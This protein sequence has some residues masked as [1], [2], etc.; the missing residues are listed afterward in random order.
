MRTK[1]WTTKE[2]VH[3]YA[4]RLRAVELY[5]RLGKR[6][7]G[8]SRHLGYPTTNSIG[9]APRVPAAS[10]PGYSAGSS[11]AEMLRESEAGGIGLYSGDES[12][13]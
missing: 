11:S 6:L 13:Q 10:P 5:I 12:A 4:D 9:L 3:V 8:N 2:V 1:T 7:Y